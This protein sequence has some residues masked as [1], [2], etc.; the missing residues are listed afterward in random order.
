MQEWVLLTKIYLYHSKRLLFRIYTCILVKNPGIG[1]FKKSLEKKIKQILRFWHY[2]STVELNTLRV[3][4][5]KLLWD[6]MMFDFWIVSC[7]FTFATHSMYKLLGIDLQ[8]DT[9]YEG[10]FDK[11]YF[12]AR[13]SKV[14][15]NMTIHFLPYIKVIKI[16]FR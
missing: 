9:F 2:F 13:K 11:S 6:Q 7:K 16:V 10:V 14:M 5:W 4:P 3:L 15:K 12:W 8:T 1:I